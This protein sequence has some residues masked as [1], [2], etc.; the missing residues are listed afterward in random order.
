MNLYS[1]LW[2]RTNRL[3]FTR[4]SDWFFFRIWGHCSAGPTKWNDKI[5]FDYIAPTHSIR[6]FSHS[7]LSINFEYSN[8]KL[9]FLEF[10]NPNFGISNLKFSNFEHPNSQNS[11]FESS[12]FECFQ[13]IASSFLESEK[14]QSETFYAVWI[15]CFICWCCVLL[16]KCIL[17]INELGWLHVTLCL[18]RN[19]KKKW[20]WNFLKLNNG[21]IINYWTNVSCSN[22]NCCL[23]SMTWFKSSIFE[24]R[25]FSF[26]ME[27]SNFDW[28][29]RNSNYNYNNEWSGKLG[30]SLW[31]YYFLF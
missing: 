31:N 21:I 28:K 20:K 7:V 30:K 1:L 6:F 12:I 22:S 8:S 3:I 23:I 29:F 2:S 16:I 13:S 24:F 11:N 5:T 4:I 26:C 19:R 14:F 27:I 25:N 17:L 10:Q 9:R 15:L 18:N